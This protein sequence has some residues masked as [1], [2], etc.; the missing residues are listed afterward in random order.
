[1]ASKLAKKTFIPLSSDDD[2]DEPIYQPFSMGKRL[3]VPNSSNGNRRSISLS[4]IPQSPAASPSP[5]LQ[6]ETSELERPPSAI[7]S[8]SQLNESSTRRKI[9]PHLE[10]CTEEDCDICESKF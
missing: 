10:Y 5:R 6:R 4:P 2:D 1:M 9:I 3:K 8:T 7:S